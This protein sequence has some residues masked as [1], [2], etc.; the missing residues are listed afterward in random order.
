[1][2][3]AYLAAEGFQDQLAAGIKNVTGVYGRLIVSDAPPK[4][5]A[6]AQN[7]WYDVETVAIKSV[8]APCCLR[9]RR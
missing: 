6:W 8:A 5:A 3:T 9:D 7:I 2:T 4:R 1:M